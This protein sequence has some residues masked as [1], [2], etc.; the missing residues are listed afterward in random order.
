MKNYLYLYLSVFVASLGG[1]LSGYDTGVIS[2]ALLYID[3]T[4]N[5]TPYLLGLLVSSV[6]M[7]AVFGAL[8]NGF[9]ADKFGRKKV[10]IITALI[11]MFGSVFCAI[12][13]NPEQLILSRIMVG[14]AVGVVSFAC[15]L[16]LGEISPKEKRGQMVSFYQLAITLGILFSYIVNYFCASLTANWRAMLFCG[17]VPALFLFI[18]MIFLKDTPR[19]LIAQNR[20][21]EARKILEKTTPDPEF[22]IDEIKKTLVENNSKISKKL[23]MPFAIGIGIMFVQIMTGINAIIYYAPVIFKDLGF[24]TN[25]EVLFVT[26]F[27]GLINFLMTFVAIALVDK[28]GRKPLLYIGLSGMMLSLSVLSLSYF[29]DFSFMKYFAVVFCALYIVFFSMSLGPVGLLLISEVFPLEFRA[30]A[31]SF[32]I[33]SNFIFNFI[34]TA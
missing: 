26:I 4:F 21:D 20:V 19:W 5:I 34:I 25:K 31:M 29:L 17:S 33:I 7:G 30:R 28:L 23:F 8:I 13:Q 9:L 27:I 18:G 22:E 16:Y 1:L 12:S 32:A 14:I 10:L 11:F 3:K 24:Q 6:S 2:G 15:P